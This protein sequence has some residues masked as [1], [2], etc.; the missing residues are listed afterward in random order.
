MTI[1]DATVA[2]VAGIAAI[3]AASLDAAQWDPAG[4]LEQDCRVAI[5]AGVVAAF[6]VTRQVAPGE[7]EILNLAV[8]PAWRRRGLAL[9]LL[10]GELAR[11]RGAWHLEVRESNLA[12]IAL[13]QRAGFQS[14][15]RRENYYYDPPEAAIVMRMVS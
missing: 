10:T 6:L 9:R 11:S 5:E 8:G 3:Q 12:A 1:R 15:G 4:Y 14:F 13:Y 2:D 7:R